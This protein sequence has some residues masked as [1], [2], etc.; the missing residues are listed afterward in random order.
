MAIAYILETISPKPFD[1]NLRM[2]NYCHIAEN[3][4]EE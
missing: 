3:K 4:A 1:K 2:D